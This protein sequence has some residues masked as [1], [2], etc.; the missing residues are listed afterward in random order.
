MKHHS[1]LLLV[2][3]DMNSRFSKLTDTMM[4]QET[5]NSDAVRL[6][7]EALKGLLEIT[8]GLDARLKKLEEK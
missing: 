8:N 1:E 3:K 5:R 4:D 7:A 2:V 6:T